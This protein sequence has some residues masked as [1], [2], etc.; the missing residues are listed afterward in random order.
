MKSVSLKS[1]TS[2]LSPKS[3]P[4]RKSSD[5]L[6]ETLV[7][8]KVHHETSKRTKRTGFNSKA[9][10]ITDETI[11]Q[12]LKN[13]EGQK[14]EAE[15]EKIRNKIE[16]K[17]ERQRKKRRKK[18]KRKRKG[19]KERRGVVILF[20][21]QLVVGF[22]A[23]LNHYMYWTIETM[24]NVLHVSYLAIGTF[25]LMCKLTMSEKMCVRHTDGHTHTHTHKLSTVTEYVCR[26][27]ITNALRSKK[28]H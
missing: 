20:I 4:S 24:S 25:L 23:S 11:R 28:P 27:L 9:V 16:R 15:A 1:G 17:L 26:G 5:V 19:I 7:L 3:L 14:A 12:E 2:R 8:P 6:S 18:R 13:K 21:H 10:C 22:R